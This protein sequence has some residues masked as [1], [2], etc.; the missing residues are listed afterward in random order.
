[1]NE[2]IRNHIELKKRWLRIRDSS[3]K[4]LL[5]FLFH[6][7]YWIIS[8]FLLVFSISTF[9]ALSKTNQYQS[10]AQLLIAV[11]REN[12]NIDPTIERG[13]LLD[14]F[15]EKEKTIRSEIAI[16][17]SQLVAEKVV[18]KLGAD[19]VTHCDSKMSN[20]KDNI[21]NDNVVIG[22][23]RGR[24]SGDFNGAVGTLISGFSVEADR[25]LINLSYTYREPYC[26]QYLLNE[27]ILAYNDRHIELNKMFADISYFEES[28]KEAYS[29][30]AEIDE[31]IE[32][33][34]SNNNISSIK[35]QK[36]SLIAQIELLQNRIDSTSSNILAKVSKITSIENNLKER[37][38]TIELN[39]TNGIENSFIND[40]KPKLLELKLQ[41][42]NLSTRF[43]ADYRPLIEIRERI[44]IA[45]QAILNEPV[46]RTQVTS[47][48]DD[49]YTQLEIMKAVE[50][51]EF[52][53]FIGEQASLSEMISQRKQE[54]KDLGEKEVTLEKLQR[55]KE[56]RTLE[57]QTNIERLQRA[58]LN[59][60]L[61]MEK[62]SNVKVLQPPKLILNPISPNRKSAILLGLL[63]G[64]AG[65]IGVAFVIEYIDDT[66]A[67]SEDVEKKLGLRVLTYVTYD[68][69]IESSRYF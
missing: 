2:T 5:E 4:D 20:L 39:K 31:E 37:S 19:F 43:T 34:R 68:E 26:A 47:G 60:S 64:L 35:E 1:M 49:Y 16:M 54:L 44:K 55:E 24:K 27:M 7:K 3:L 22:S 14:V 48:L 11:G 12:I 53:S 32:R 29:R 25:Y 18:N 69:A 59:E 30:L 8:I 10:A 17:T 56:I 67:T 42:A 13:Q 66:M 9:V 36:F 62:I 38:R 65:G 63:L 46:T 6:R 33:F 41:E 50:E 23:E 28:E 21:K 58:K 45:E 51:S 15:Q 40:V 57:Y 52:K 61:D